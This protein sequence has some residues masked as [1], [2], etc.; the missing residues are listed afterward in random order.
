MPGLLF[1]CAIRA[2]LIAIATATVLWVM[3]V[4]TA[5]ARHALWT[6]VVV[7]MLLLPLWTAWGP[8]VSWRVLPPARHSIESVAPVETSN[9][10]RLGV[11]PSP[12]PTYASRAAWN[13][14]D[15]L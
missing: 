11:A 15:F 7:L 13:W 9:I 5:P 6:G 12:V 4:K 8:R 1:E 2:V 3:R 10:A 14:W